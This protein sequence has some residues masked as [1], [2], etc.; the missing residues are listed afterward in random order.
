[1]SLLIVDDLT[2]AAIW[3]TLVVEPKADVGVFLT[4]PAG[5]ETG[6]WEAHVYPDD[7][8][9]SQLVTFACVPAGLT[10]QATLTAANVDSLLPAGTTRF[11]GH[12]DWYRNAPDGTRRG[13]V[14]GDFIVNA[15]LELR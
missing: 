6:S 13:Y 14:K 4:V 5:S 1:V 7:R 2:L 15:G 3:W 8:R 12:W 9:L 11:R 10:I